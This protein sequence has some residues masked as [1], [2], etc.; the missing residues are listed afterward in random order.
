MSYCY[1]DPVNI[2]IWKLFLQNNLNSL[3]A[4]LE[5]YLICK[6]LIKKFGILHLTL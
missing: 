6:M 1:S 3:L 5:K 2:L 4:I